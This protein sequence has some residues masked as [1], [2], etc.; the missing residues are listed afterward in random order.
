MGSSQGHSLMLLKGMLEFAQVSQCRGLT[1]LCAQSSRVL[2]IISKL[3]SFKVCNILLFCGLKYIYTLVQFIYNEYL[4]QKVHESEFCTLKHLHILYDIHRNV[5]TC[6]MPV[7]TMAKRWVPGICS[8]KWN[9][10]S[11]Q[12]FE[13]VV[14]SPDQT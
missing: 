6:N 8:W 10:F 3:L 1:E 4:P 2:S 14:G 5:D 12:V 11:H 13:I 9:T 7:S